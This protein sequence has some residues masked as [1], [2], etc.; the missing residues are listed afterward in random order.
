[1]IIEIL[2][3]LYTPH[4]TKQI[5]YNKQVSQKRAPLAACREPARDHNRPQNMSYVS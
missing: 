1:M 2:E 4:P 3:K 5:Q